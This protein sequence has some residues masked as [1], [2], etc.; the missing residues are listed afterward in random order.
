MAESELDSAPL[1]E[2]L[3]LVGDRWALLE[4]YV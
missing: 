1:A 2:A 3:A 4:H